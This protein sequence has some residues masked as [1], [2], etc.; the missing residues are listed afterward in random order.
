MRREKRGRGEKKGEG[1][2]EEGGGS[3]ENGGGRKG[4]EIRG[5]EGRKRPPVPYPKW[6]RD[7]T[8]IFRFLLTKTVCQINTT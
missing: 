8:N 6:V 2:V 1:E 3:E 5:G 7:L 4:G